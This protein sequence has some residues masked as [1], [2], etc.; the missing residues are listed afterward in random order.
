MLYI[1]YM[2][3]KYKIHTEDIQDHTINEPNAQ[4]NNGLSSVELANNYQNLPGQ[5][6]IHELK[7]ILNKAEIN[8][9]AGK[10][11]SHED[12]IRESAKW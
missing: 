4:Y 3:K 10:V 2:K 8:I 7:E 5:V 12:V 11:I 1:L 9:A 6:S